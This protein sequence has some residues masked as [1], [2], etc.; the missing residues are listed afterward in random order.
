VFLFLFMWRYTSSVL[1][2]VLIP[3]N[4][5][6]FDDLF[7]F[8][9]LLPQECRHFV[10]EGSNSYDVLSLSVIAVMISFGVNAHLDFSVQ[11]PE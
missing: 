5:L 2:A 10:K 8:Y 3:H 4:C 11:T 9:V 7:C 1:F 6:S